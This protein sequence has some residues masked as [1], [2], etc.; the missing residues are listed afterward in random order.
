MGGEGRNEI[1]YYLLV[2]ATERENGV[3]KF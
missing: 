3:G 1:E 2:R